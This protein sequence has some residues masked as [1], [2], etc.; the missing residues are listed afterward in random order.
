MKI[1][2]IADL[3]LG[4]KIQG[5]SLLVDQKYFLENTIKY[6]KNHDISHLIIAGDIYDI[7]S[8]SGEAI[9]LFS[10]FLGMLKE[11]GIKAFIISGNHDSNDRLGY[12]S[13]LIKDSNIYINTSIKSGINPISADGINYYL[14]PYAN[15]SEINSIYDKEFKTYEDALKYIISLI[16]LDKSKVNICVSHN[17]VLSSSNSILFGG[18]E[19][20]IIGTIQ[21]IS[22]SVFK[23]FNY[24]ALGH[25]H[26]PQ[27]VATNI[28]Y[29]GSPLTYHIDE[30]KYEK[31]YTIID[32]EGSNISVKTDKIKPYREVIEITDTFDN[33]INN[34]NEYKNYYVY[35][36]ITDNEVENAMAKLKNKYPYALSLR[37]LK[38]DNSNIDITK[39]IEDIESISID[40]LFNKLFNMQKGK[41]LSDYQK[42]IVL[43]LLKE[44]EEDEA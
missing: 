40:E 31:T 10:D 35:A 37:Y 5:Y 13:N 32:V 41:D 39:K 4:K 8:P 34:Y 15:L 11:S 17:L 19:E 20:P 22:S 9:N 27:K 18:S 16:K 24:V 21:N 1:L 42:N 26:K 43:N 29:S 25:I 38:D 2:H 6:M 12:A 36:T 33:I 23:D 7:S 3:H 30:A 28:Y 14:L 44:S